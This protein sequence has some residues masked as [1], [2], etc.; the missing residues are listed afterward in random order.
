MNQ[1]LDRLHPYPF[2][3]QARLLEGI[4]P[5]ADLAPI[6]FALG[7]PKH[8]APAFL[9]E[10]LQDED[11]LRRGLGTYPATRGLPE[12]REAI[13]SWLC[14]RYGISDGGID[15]DS[16]VLPV[17][18]TREALFAISQTLVDSSG[19]A[20]ILMPN[21]FYQI[22]EGAALL[23]GV[24]PTYIP[25]TAA[26]GFLPDF[27]S[28]DTRTWQQCQ[29]LY[30]CTP[31]NPTG[32]IMGKEEFSELLQLSD[33]YDFVIASDECYSEIY[34]DENSPPMGLL[35]ACMKLG[36][37]DFKNCLAFNS[38][39]KRSNL[40]GLRSGFV[41]GDSDLLAKFLLYRTYHGSAMPVHNQIISAMA[42]RDEQHVALNRDVYRSK[43]DKV[44]GILQHCLPV[45]KPMAAF[46]LW[47]DTGQDDESFARQLYAKQNV[48]IL[49]GSY[50]SRPDAAGNNPGHQHVRIALVATID[51]CVEAAT[52]IRDFLS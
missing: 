2:E 42:W 48:T 51:E 41:A 28:I 24:T 37:T 33:H 23:A 1:H 39:S 34:D 31:G 29:L 14:R 50:L 11:L 20:N 5:P 40:P 22:Y 19:A 27:E 8:A 21:P 26:T 35:E 15:P 38:L 32:A 44:L 36:R 13:A 7:E 17:N 9:V 25:C 49:P 18:G 12:L 3:R 4:T 47:P 10:A 43:F 46:Y 16:Q 6:S 52:R 45:K 30:L